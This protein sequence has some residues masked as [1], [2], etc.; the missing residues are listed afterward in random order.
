M[1]QEEAC[2]KCYFKFE[3]DDGT[4]VTASCMVEE[5][6]W[7]RGEK[8][9]KWLRHFYKPIIRRSL[10]LKFDQEIGPEKGSWKGGTI[11]TSCEMKPGD[12]PE[13]AFRRWCEVS[14]RSKYRKFTTRYIGPSDPVATIL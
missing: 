7:H 5:R 9:F 12:T 11:G 6:E 3:D 14:H 4:I 13:D 2:P 8:S 10:S 1:E